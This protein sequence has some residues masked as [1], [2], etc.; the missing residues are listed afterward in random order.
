MAFGSTT[1]SQKTTKVLALATPGTRHAIPGRPGAA[2]ARDIAD[3]IVTA[4]IT[5]T[6]KADST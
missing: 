6:D 3:G 4:L 2:T 5:G 1:A